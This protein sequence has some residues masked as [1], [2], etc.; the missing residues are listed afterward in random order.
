MKLFFKM[1]LTCALTLMCAAAAMAVGEDNSIGRFGITWTFDRELSEQAEPGKYQYG[2]F[3]NGDFWVRNPDEE[4]REV[5]VIGI[6]PESIAVQFE[7]KASGGIT[8][9]FGEDATVTQDNTDATGKVIAQHDGTLYLYDVDGEFNTTDTISD[10]SASM[11][12][13]TINKRIINGSMLEPPVQR[14]QGYDSYIYTWHERRGVLYG[15]AYDDALNAARHGG[16][17]LSIDNPLVI[18]PDDGQA[19]S[20]VSTGSAAPELRN[21]RRLVRTAAILTVV[22]DEPSE[23][24]FRPSYFP[25]ENKAVEFNIDVFADNDVYNSVLESKPPVPSVPD[26]ED[27]GGWFEGPWLQHVPHWHSGGIVARRHQHGYGRQDA[28]RVGVAALMLNLDYDDSTKEKLLTRFVQLGI[29]LFGAVQC[30]R[31]GNGVYDHWRANGG[32]NHGRKFP[33][34][35]AGLVLG[36]EEMM[37]IGRRTGQYVYYDDDG[38]PHEDYGEGNPPPDYFHFAE[39]D[40]IFYVRQSDIENRDYEQDDSGLPEW[41][42]RQAWMP[43][44]GSSNWNARYRNVVGCSLSGYVLALHIMDSAVEAR[45]G[46]GARDLWN[47]PAIFDYTDR[48]VRK[49]DGE[50]GV[51]RAHFHRFQKDMWDAYRDDYPPLWTPDSMRR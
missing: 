22:A 36:D 19:E 1:Y 26:W 3:A 16:E 41:R 39:D 43:G 44:H 49:Y 9:T 18:A 14:T 32:H 34:L 21:T 33:V 30:A 20:L 7:F 42:I 37:T 38:E 11:V 51:N 29:D 5:R 28:T 12:A 24:S 47:N 2:R 27:A 13:D 17:P 10:G 15:P 40:Q 6:S 48:Y 45:Y 31:Q 46:T 8:G 25:I 35:F 23:G 50:H 4:S